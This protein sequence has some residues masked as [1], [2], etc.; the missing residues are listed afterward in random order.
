MERRSNLPFQTFPACSICDGKGFVNFHNA[1]K[2]DCPACRYESWDNKDSVE[3]LL[4]EHNAKRIRIGY[5]SQTK[6]EPQIYWKR[7]PSEW[8]TKAQSMKKLSEKQ[9]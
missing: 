5:P 3:L 8:K 6:S 9:Q 2:F 1:I 7:T 4:S